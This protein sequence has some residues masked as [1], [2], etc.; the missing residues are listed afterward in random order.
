MAFFAFF[1]LRCF[2]VI[3][4]NNNDLRIA[5]R[6]NK[7]FRMA[8]NSP[9]MTASIKNRIRLSNMALIPWFITQLHFV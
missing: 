2:L 1:L 9:V 3:S 6:L 4:Q 7:C 5:N 8:P